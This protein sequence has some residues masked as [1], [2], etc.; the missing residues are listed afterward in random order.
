MLK[1]DSGVSKSIYNLVMID[2]TC[3]LFVCFNMKQ[4]IGCFFGCTGHVA[5]IPQRTENQLMLNCIQQFLFQ[6]SSNKYGETS[7]NTRNPEP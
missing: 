4:I 7:E 1:N 6:N 5:N 2:E 3:S